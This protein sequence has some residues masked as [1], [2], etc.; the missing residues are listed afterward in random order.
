LPTPDYEP[1]EESEIDG[2]DSDGII[3]TLPR[4]RIRNLRSYKQIERFY[5]ETDILGV[6]LKH[7]ING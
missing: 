3:L 1:N 5:D 6:S 4:I 7:T 2:Q